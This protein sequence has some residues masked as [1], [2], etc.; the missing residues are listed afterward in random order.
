[1]ARLSIKNKIEDFIYKNIIRRILFSSR[2]GR[3]SSMGY[4]DSGIN[5]DHI[6]KNTPSGYIW[7]GRFVDKILLS[8]PAAKATRE[9]KDKIVEI[10]RVEV[11]KNKNRGIRTKIVDLASG[12][13]RYLVELIS[14][15]FHDW[16]EAL[17][18]DIDKRSLAYGKKLSGNKPIIFKRSNVTKIGNKYK[19]LSD[20]IKWKPNCILISGLLE[21]LDDSAVK[22]IFNDCFSNIDNNGL[23]LFVTQK[24][25]PNRKLIE[26]VGLTKTGKSWTLSYRVPEILAGWMTNAGYRDIRYTIDRWGMYIFL[27]G[28]K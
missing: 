5:F 17:C 8:L 12:P 25:N 21:Y 26:K 16:T 22:K 10:L 1:M 7:I 27:T 13:S 18:F 4:A 14:E 24:N 11:E 3:K 6:Y 2:L 19:N 20:R 28:R 15:D 23:A 9:R